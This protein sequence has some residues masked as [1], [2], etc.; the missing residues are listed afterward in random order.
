MWLKVVIVILFI[1]NIFALSKAFYTLLLNQGTG[2]KQTA[3]LL[4]I[5]VVLG[6]LLLLVVGYGVWSG[7]LAISAP[8]HNPQ[9]P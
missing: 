3:S 1:A 7:D 9:T 8:W 6:A 2:S 4:A 5:R